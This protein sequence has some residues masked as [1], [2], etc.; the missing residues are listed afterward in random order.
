MEIISEES[1]HRERTDSDQAFM[2]G[3]LSFSESLMG[4]PAEELLQD[5]PPMND[6]REALKNGTGFL[7]TLLALSRSLEHS[8]QKELENLL[9]LIPLP[10]EVIAIALSEAMFWADDIVRTFSLLEH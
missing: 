2:T 4:S 9:S 8:D 10:E 3:M 6:L 1:I 5:L 7:G